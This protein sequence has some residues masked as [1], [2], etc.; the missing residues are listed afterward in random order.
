MSAI[1][2][3]RPFSLIIEQAPDDNALIIKAVDKL[4]LDL[5]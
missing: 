1:K 4:Q 2:K 3:I 5:S